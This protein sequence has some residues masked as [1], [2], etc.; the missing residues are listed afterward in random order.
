MPKREDTQQEKRGSKYSKII[1]LDFL[2]QEYIRR[3][4][5]IFDSYYGLGM[6][7]SNTALEGQYSPKFPT[8]V[9]TLSSPELGNKLAEYTAWYSYGAD[10]F[11]YVLVACTH[12][13]SEMAKVMDRVVGGMVEGKGNIDAKK[14]KARSSDEYILLISY[15]QKIEGLKILL[16]N[17]LKNYDKCIQSLSREVS[18]RENNAGF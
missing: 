5:E 9:A 4:D 2:P 14:A 17:E 10:K 7:P 8:D 15:H 16:D 3:I 13:E 12:I 1:N 11:K 6:R 18:R